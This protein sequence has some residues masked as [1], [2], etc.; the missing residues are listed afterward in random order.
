[1]QDF[2]MGQNDF[3]KVATLMPL[4]SQAIA[5]PGKGTVSTKSLFNYPGGLNT[6][7]QSY[8]ED[9]KDNAPAQIDYLIKALSG[10]SYVNMDLVPAEVQTK[11]NLKV[12]APA[13][14]PG[15]YAMFMMYD[16]EVVPKGAWGKKFESMP[17][18][19]T[20][21]APVEYA[22]LVCTLSKICSEM[23]L[24]GLVIDQ[25]P[26]INV[27]D[28]VWPYWSVRTS[29]ATITL[30]IQPTNPGFLAE[31]ED[32]FTNVSAKYST[33]FKGFGGMGL[34]FQ[35]FPKA[36][37][38]A[39]EARGGN[40]MGL[41]GSDHDRYV[42]EIPGLYSNGADEKVMNAW[43]AEFMDRVQDRLKTVTVSLKAKGVTVG[44]YNPYFMNDAGPGQDVMSSYKDAAKFAKIQRSVD[45]DGL[46][47]KRAGGYKFKYTS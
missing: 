40:A 15:Y 32:I 29:F 26:Q 5:M 18:I 14:T 7:T 8:E 13:G 38:K 39:A 19:G 41:L 9:F 43:V 12:N 21:G 20:W 24:V 27:S 3:P 34:V 33:K 23:K 45:P 10:A 35:P 25:N 36:F 28:P 22:Q 11:L 4:G 2:V 17:A 31:V 1:M 47:S 30:P 42:L 44:Q 46:F 16:G 37:G 6:S